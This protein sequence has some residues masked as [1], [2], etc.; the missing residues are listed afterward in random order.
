MEQVVALAAL[1]I[2]L[3]GIMLPQTGWSVPKWLA[4]TM[5]LGSLIVL[6]ILA[7]ATIAPHREQLL[8]PLT[9]IKTLLES[10][11]AQSTLWQANLLVVALIALTLFVVRPLDKRLSRIERL[12]HRYV[13][14]RH[15]TTEQK[16]KIT[17]A[18][19]EVTPREIILQ[20]ASRSSEVDLYKDDFRKAFTDAGWAI[21]PGQVDE[22][23]EGIRIVG[24]CPP[25][26]R[27]SV[28]AT[29]KAIA[30]AFASAGIQHD[31][32]S[33]GGSATT[34]TTITITIGERR[35]GDSDERDIQRLEEEMAL[36]ES[37]KRRLGAS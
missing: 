32:T 23:W 31:H 2:A 14:P 34:E 17:E 9:A 24:K 6:L 18:L 36:L 10:S 11:H 19:R 37:D 4:R 33:G 22:Y 3:F 27:E 8:A 16:T 25:H 29:V 1:I 35:K 26:D 12:L 28:N 13:L 5:V 20:S 21:K 7:I 30:N 15:L